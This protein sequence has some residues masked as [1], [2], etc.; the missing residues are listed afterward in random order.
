MNFYV[1]FTE[2]ERGG[3]GREGQITVWDFLYEIPYSSSSLHDL[4]AHM[5]S[6][7][8]QRPAVSGHC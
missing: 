7:V 8:V 6:I 1:Y 4:P 2:R 3:E 5:Y